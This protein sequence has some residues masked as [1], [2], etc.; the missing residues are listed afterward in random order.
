MDA[1][2]GSSQFTAPS[3]SVARNCDR[4]RDGPPSKR[5]AGVRLPTSYVRGNDSFRR[6]NGIP[7]HELSGTAI[8]LPY[9]QI[10]LAP[11]QLIGILLECLGLLG[12]YLSAQCRHDA[13]NV[14]MLI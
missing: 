14:Y 1:L 4:S 3:Y 8:G 5:R 13:P 11:P 10:P 12:W 2:T 9:S 6:P 7:R